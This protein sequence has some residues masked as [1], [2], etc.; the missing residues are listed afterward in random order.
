MNFTCYRT[1]GHATKYNEDSIF[2]TLSG[3]RKNCLLITKA[4]ITGL[5]HKLAPLPHLVTRNGFCLDRRKKNC[6]LLSQVK[7][8]E[9]SQKAI[10]DL[11][12]LTGLSFKV[13]DHNV[14]RANV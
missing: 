1:V 3:S 9:M 8:V 10:L 11:L 2:P 12:F 4:I 7:A 6:N 14:D 5:I 13:K